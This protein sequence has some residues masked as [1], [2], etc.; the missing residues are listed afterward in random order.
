MTTNAFFSRTQ[1]AKYKDRRTHVTIESE[2]KIAGGKTGNKI[3]IDSFKVY[4]GL[5]LRGF[6]SSRI[7]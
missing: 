3:V 7:T 5:I 4:I 2:M 6:Q 1:L